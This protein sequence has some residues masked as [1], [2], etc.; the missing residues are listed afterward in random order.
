MVSYI[1]CEVQARNNHLEFNKWC[2]QV[3]K[4]LD[5]GS[6]KTP[7]SEREV[8]LHPHFLEIALII[9]QKMPPIPNQRVIVHFTNCNFV[10][11]KLQVA[12]ILKSTGDVYEDF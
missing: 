5:V 4:G 12:I 7:V 1:S 3:Y 2:L 11:L 8:G 6:A 10:G 9:V